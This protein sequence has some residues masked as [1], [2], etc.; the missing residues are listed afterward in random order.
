MRVSLRAK[1]ILPSVAIMLIIMTVAT[2]IMYKG[3]YKAVNRKATE[4]VVSTSK[5]RAEYLDSVINRLAI[6]I[7]MLSNNNAIQTQNKEIINQL[8]DSIPKSDSSVLSAYV[9]YADKQTLMK[10]GSI[11]SGYDP[12]SRDWYTQAQSVKGKP[13][14]TEPYKDAFTDKTCITVAKSFKTKSGLDGVV[15]VDV[16]LNSISDVLGDTKIGNSGYLVLVSKNGTILYHPDNTLVEQSKNIKDINTWGSE[17]LSNH[18]GSLEANNASKVL[19]QI[20]YHEAEKSGWM[21]I[22]ILPETEYGMDIKSGARTAI[23]INII[24]LAICIAAIWLMVNKI[25]KSLDTVN[26]S[27]K[28]IEKGNLNTSI[29]INRKDEIGDIQHSAVS[30]LNSLREMINAAKTATSSI[31]EQTNIL[32]SIQTETSVLNEAV[33]ESMDTVSE[34][35]ENNSS[36]I[37]EVN[38]SMSEVLNTTQSVVS[39]IK[40][41]VTLSK[42]AVAQADNGTIAMESS[43][44]SM[45]DIKIATDEMF[46]RITTLAKQ[47]TDVN[48]IVNTISAISEQTNLL[49]LNASI[50]AARAGEAGRGF[51]VVADEVRKLAEETAESA[52]R[53]NDIVNEVLEGISKAEQA[54]RYKQE[55]VASSLEKSNDVDMA[56]NKIRENISNVDIHL[57][58]VSQQA[59]QQAELLSEITQATETVSKS[60]E[61]TALLTVTAN[62]K[63][64][65]QLEGITKINTTIAELKQSTDSLSEAIGKFKL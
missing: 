37:E 49:A 25:L 21:A 48:G 44:K 56:L 9:G 20:G 30:Q 4:S 33:G 11:P 6:E 23:V 46:V 39:D 52:N 17:V 38:A 53:A 40:E 60:I 29:K 36:S 42:E 27:M 7:E 61:E 45:Q 31:Q 34:N 14:V 64:E 22:A 10:P 57:D 5:E 3:G 62:N 50:E 63:R 1:L 19:S 65:E 2:F 43:S 24:L 59:T 47:S 16:D 35:T 12:T 18:E 32:H 55:L 58:N 8:L 28:E 54:V 51:S 15:A 41:A 13:I 26:K